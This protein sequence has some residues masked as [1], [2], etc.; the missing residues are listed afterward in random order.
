[1]KF[2]TKMRNCNEDIGWCTCHR[3]G[4][5]VVVDNENEVGGIYAKG[6]PVDC[7][8]ENIKKYA[9][10]EFWETAK[11]KPCRLC[12]SFNCCDAMDEEV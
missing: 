5:T 4:Q 12:P 1:M 6:K 10:D 9:T 2:R 3:K 8:E 11:K 7:T